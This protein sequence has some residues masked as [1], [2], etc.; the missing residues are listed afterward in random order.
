MFWM[1]AKLHNV[2]E[3]S[4]KKKNLELNYNV[5]KKFWQCYVAIIK[6]NLVDKTGLMIRNKNKI[7]MKVN[8]KYSWNKLIWLSKIR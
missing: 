2:C 1:C 8:F 7:W 6:I 4:K 5:K 3:I